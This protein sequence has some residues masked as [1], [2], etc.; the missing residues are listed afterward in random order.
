MALRRIDNPPNPYLTEQREWL[1]PPPKTTVEIYEETAKS[2]LSEN[3]SPD[4]P[5]RWSVNPYRGCQHACAYCYARP[6]HEYLGMGAG[7]DFDTKLIAK[8]NAPDLLRATF[9]KP[10]WRG[11][12]VTFSGVTDC[13]QPIESVYELTRGCL[14]VCRSFRNP[15]SIITKSVLVLRDADLL[16]NLQTTAGATVF[17]SIPFADDKTA[18]LI[19]PQTPPPSKRFDAMRR[20]SDAGV[21][22]GIMVAPIIP[23]LNDTQIPE[24]LRRAAEAG[25]ACACFMPLRLPGSV[26]PV[27]LSRLQAT[28]PGRAKRVESRIREMRGGKLNDPRFCSRMRGDGAYW[29]NIRSLFNLLRKRSGLGKVA[30]DHP[31]REIVSDHGRSGSTPRAA[32]RAAG[33]ENRTSPQMLFGFAGGA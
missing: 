22:V 26:T 23:G 15:V 27:F 3:D 19:E 28:M 14:E 10:S 25:A 2:I 33:M 31:N 6:T 29:H 9:S 12:P 24:I 17:Q 32:D 20:L 5:F 1:G 8:I 13:Y 4:V 11:E 21:R 30:N 18:R 7:T 16:V